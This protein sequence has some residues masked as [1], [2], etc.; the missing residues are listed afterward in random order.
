MGPRSKEGHMDKHRAAVKRSFQPSIAL[1]SFSDEEQTLLK[2]YGT[3][4]DCLAMGK[5]EP[6]TQEQL[7]FVA[8][9]NQKK[10]PVTIFELVWK[11]YCHLAHQNQKDLAERKRVIMEKI[12]KNWARNHRVSYYAPNLLSGSFTPNLLSECQAC[13]KPI[14]NCRCSG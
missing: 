13:G 3:W 7:H 6:Y 11:K 1:D 5:I 8:V 10:N 2:K 14:N 9:V 4:M 12:R